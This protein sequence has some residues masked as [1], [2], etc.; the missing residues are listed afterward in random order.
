[1]S[2]LLNPLRSLRPLQL[3]CYRRDRQDR[4][5]RKATEKIAPNFKKNS[6]RT[7]RPLRLIAP[8]GF[9]SFMRN[10]DFY[11]PL[12]YYIVYDSK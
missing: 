3:H 4:Q 10:I 12:G 1:M 2:N 8:C 6:L 11:I 5:A 9:L 7:L